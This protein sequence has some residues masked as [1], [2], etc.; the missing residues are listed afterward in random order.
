MVK[1]GREW[2]TASFAREA[3]AEWRWFALITSSRVNVSSSTV[4]VLWCSSLDG[5][6][7]TNVTLCS[8]LDS[9]ADCTKRFYGLTPHPMGFLTVVISSFTVVLYDTCT[10]REQIT[11]AGAIGPPLGSASPLWS[12]VSDVHWQ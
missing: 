6:L 11:L 2:G 3:T 7:L 9:V 12:N 1:S 8:P 4:N 5:S 10:D